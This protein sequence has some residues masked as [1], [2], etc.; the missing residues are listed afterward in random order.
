MIENGTEGIMNVYFVSVLFL[1]AAFVIIGIVVGRKV[2]TTADY[3]VAG[4]N[5]GTALIVCTLI[6]S[7]LSTVAFM[8]EVG[9]TYDGF[10]MPYLI[11]VAISSLGYGFGARYFGVYLR[12]SQALTLPEFFA[13]RFDSPRIRMLSSIITVAGITAYLVGVQQGGALLLMLLTDTSYMVSLILVLVGYGFFTFYSG[14]KGIVVTDSIMFMIFGGMAFLSIPFIYRSTGGWPQAIIETALM[15]EKPGILSATGVTEGAGAFMGGPVDTIT[16]GVVLGVVWFVVIASSPWQASRYLLAKNEQVVLRSG[17]VATFLVLAMLLALHL[18]TV[19]LNNLN[20]NI[21]PSETV[22]IWAALNHFPM[23][24]GVVV[25]GGLM[26]AVLSSCST[27][28]SLIGFSVANDIIPK[29]IKGEEKSQVKNSRIVMVIVALVSL[30]ITYYQPPAVMWIGFFAATLFACSWAVA[31]I[32]SIW[33]KNASESGAFFSMLVGGIVFVATQTLRY[34]AIVSFPTILRPEVLGFVA[35]ILGYVIFN[36][37]S[38]IKD[39][40]RAFREKILINEELKVT[41]IAELKKTANITKGLICGGVLL[42]VYFF[43]IYYI[44]YRQAMNMMAFM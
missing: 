2:K 33:F 5:C 21:S 9:Y 8:G 36:R 42:S 18:A 27:F 22:Y 34:F 28:L 38:Q 29:I 19:T 13:R 12:R 6:A 37:P 43:V 25:C 10:L 24:M 14:S 20:P 31:A 3:Y 23:W 35:S 15:T 7:Y 40:E 39:S 4:R 16:W 17:A 41:P 44:P 1:L 26:A 11:L 32:A 30:V